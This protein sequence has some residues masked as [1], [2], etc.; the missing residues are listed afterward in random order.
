MDVTVL[1]SKALLTWPNS[2]SAS[3][4]W[5]IAKK[6]WLIFFSGAIPGLA[7]NFIYNFNFYLFQVQH[8]YW[9][10]FK[11]IYT[12]EEKKTVESLFFFFTFSS[13]ELI[14][15]WVENI[16]CILWD[17]T[18]NSGLWMYQWRKRKNFGILPACHEWAESIVS[19]SSYKLLQDS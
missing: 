18:K 7:M 13:W 12:W 19:H 6:L 4:L 16:F 8:Y 2:N 10:R 1:R 17:T 3:V 14:L 5:Y 11:L 9:H 15:L